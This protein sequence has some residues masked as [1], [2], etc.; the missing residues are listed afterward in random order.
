VG[1]SAASASSQRRVLALIV[2]DHA[3][4]G[5]IAF[6][7]PG[8]G[9]INEPL[10]ISARVK[11]VSAISRKNQITIPAEVL[12]TAGLQAGDDV[13]VTAVGAGRIEL[14]K[15]SEIIDE[16]AGKLDKA[17]YPPGYLEEVRKGWA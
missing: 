10:P 7:E 1:R 14:A 4:E 3:G 11:A 5:P 13:R 17:V 12:R 15:S 9:G 6:P 8:P 2:D 16:F